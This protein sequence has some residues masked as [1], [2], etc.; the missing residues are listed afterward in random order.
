MRKRNEG[1]SLIEIIVA[2]GLAAIFLPALGMIFSFA[3]GSA[4]QGEKYSQAYRL[5]QEG[6][7][8]IFYLKSQNDALW[9][10]QA[11][12]ANTLSGEYYQPNQVG[13]FWQLGP[14]TTSLVVT[15]PPFT[16]K[17]EIIEVCRN[18]SLIINDCGA[19]GV[20]I[21]PYTRKVISYA[22]W[23]EKGQTEEVRLEAYVTAH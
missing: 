6:M 11:T 21:D 16:R 22:T 10:W 23:L 20:S 8:T 4:S 12:P 17:I 2:V 15:R 7:E 5:A 13:D 14:K 19:P 1:F 18:L 9:D 3:I